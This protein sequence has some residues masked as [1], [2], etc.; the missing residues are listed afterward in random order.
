MDLTKLV[1]NTTADDGNIKSVLF[2]NEWI[3]LPSL[4][5]KK[6]ITPIL[7]FVDNKVKFIDINLD[8]SDLNN[9]DI[10]ISMLRPLE[11]GVRYL[12]AFRICYGSLM[13]YKM[14][15]KQLHINLANSKGLDIL[16]NNLIV[17]FVTSMDIYNDIQGNIITIEL[18][19]I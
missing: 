13:T 7:P 8:I 16:P 5:V 4:I 14:L 2:K 17:R 15:G 18:P 3:D 1:F 12:F 19:C 11:Y 10:F 6:N 9:L